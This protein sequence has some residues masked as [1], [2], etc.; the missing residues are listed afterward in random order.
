[1]TFLHMLS[2][3]K[4]WTETNPTVGAAS[5]PVVEVIGL[6]LVNR[7]YCYNHHHH[8]NNYSYYYHY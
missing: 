6:R 5:V 2:R 7:D 1:M 8:N 3:L 4:H